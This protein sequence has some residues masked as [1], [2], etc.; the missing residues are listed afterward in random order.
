MLDKEQ[1]P[2]KKK[3]GLLP[4]MGLDEGSVAHAPE[5]PKP[6]LLTGSPEAELNQRSRDEA[7]GSKIQDKLSRRPD[8]R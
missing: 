5:A 4:K 7:V 8:G 1:E 3:K 2:K 6:G